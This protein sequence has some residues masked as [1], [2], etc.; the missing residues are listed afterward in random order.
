VLFDDNV[1]SPGQLRALVRAIRRAAGGRALVMADQEGGTVRIVPWA[2][3]ERP[4]AAQAGAG[5]VRA[6]SR[7]AGRELRASGVD[8]A[9]APVAD[10]PRPGSALAGR[11]FGADPEAVAEAVGDAVAGFRAGG[12][13]PTVKHFPGL[14]AATANTDDAQVT[15]AGRPRLGPFRAAI[16]A[17]TPLMMLSHAIYP[18]LD[19]EAIAS[20]SRAVIEGLL[21]D[22]L[23]F[24]G[25]AITDSMEAE[26]VVGRSPVDVAAERS[27]RAGIDLLLTTGRGSSLRIYR[28]LLATARRS[29][30]FA[31]RVREAAGRVDALPSRPR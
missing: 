18:A 23:G 7:A 4:A 24:E 29:E 13:L 8:V 5:T 30:A 22:E 31:A 14:G 17:G 1:V 27:V 15:I 21:R 11:G 6:D 3:P 12:V 2:G 19:G 16:A 9:L 28:R 26:A 10:V 20:Q 25:V